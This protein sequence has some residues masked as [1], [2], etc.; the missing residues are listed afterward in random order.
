MKPDE[1]RKK[2]DQ[3]T[4][5]ITVVSVVTQKKLKEKQTRFFNQPISSS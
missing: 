3:T 4:A 5:L 1:F 2:K